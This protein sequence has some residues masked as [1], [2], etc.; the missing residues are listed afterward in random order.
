MT[1][2]LDP[3][4]SSWFIPQLGMPHFV[5]AGASFLQA[6]IPPH[7]RM[8]E[9]LRLY[10]RGLQILVKAPCVLKVAHLNI[11]NFNTVYK[12]SNGQ[13]GAPSSDLHQGCHHQL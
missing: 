13:N 3:K 8:P 1:L 2:E 7:A 10:P 9:L 6:A 5:H 4:Q 12:L 11:C